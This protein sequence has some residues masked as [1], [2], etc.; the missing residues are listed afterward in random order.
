MPAPETRPRGHWYQVA[1]TETLDPWWR[2]SAI[3]R[4]LGMVLS[5]RLGNH[6]QASRDLTVR[7]IAIVGRAYLGSSESDKPR[8]SVEPDELPS[9]LTGNE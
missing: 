5:N 6:T 8:E 7:K 2:A 9:L 1:R 4:H 3:V